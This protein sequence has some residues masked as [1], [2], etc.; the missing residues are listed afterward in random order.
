MLLVLRKRWVSFRFLC[1]RPVA[2]ALV[3]AALDGCLGR[4]G[5]RFEDREGEEEE[6]GPTL[7]VRMRGGGGGCILGVAEG[8]RVAVEVAMMLLWWCN[9]ETDVSYLL[10][11]L[12]CFRLA[13]SAKPP[14][15]PFAYANLPAAPLGQR[16]YKPLPY[17][18]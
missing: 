11:Y 18:M 9:S 8:G 2:V 17:H 10:E 3:G 1:G 7:E 6:V 4:E 16:V 15:V 5:G 13:H 14:L 12:V